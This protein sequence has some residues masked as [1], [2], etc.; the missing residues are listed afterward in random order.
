MTAIRRDPRCIGIEVVEQGVGAGIASRVVTASAP[1]AAKADVR[2]RS[3]TAAHFTDD[4]QPS[5]AAHD[6]RRNSHRDARG[7]A[8]SA[9][10][11]ILK[12]EAYTGRRVWAKQQKVESLVDPEDVAAGQQTRLRWRQEADWI[13]SDRRTHPQIVPDDLFSTI[14]GMLASDSLGE[15]QDKSLSPSLRASGRSLLRPLWPAHAGSLA[16]QP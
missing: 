14:Q 2:S 15:P 16:H 13:R 8:H 1:H 11:A 9:V 5:P 4:G 12:N 7:W 3:R 10:R 6:P